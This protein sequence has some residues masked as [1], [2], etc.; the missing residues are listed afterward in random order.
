MSFQL[1]IQA[2]DR[3]DGQTV[4]AHGKGVLDCADGVQMLSIGLY[5]LEPDIKSIAVNLDTPRA[6]VRRL[7]DFARC[8]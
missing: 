6:Q 8:P 4:F 5:G 1:A 2:T 3:E 7:L